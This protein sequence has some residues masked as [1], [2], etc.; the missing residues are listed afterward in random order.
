MAYT[1]SARPLENSA[2]TCVDNG[3]NEEQ[4]Y[5]IE[6]NSGHRWAEVATRVSDWCHDE[7]HVV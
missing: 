2:C 5:E 7:W 3:A 4:Q 1:A 6:M